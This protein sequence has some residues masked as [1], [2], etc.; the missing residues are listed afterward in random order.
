MGVPVKFSSK[1]DKRVLSELR[2][3]SK[4]S[5]RNISGVLTEAVSEYLERV[6]VR[7]A[8]KEAAS[9]VIDENAELL[10]RLAK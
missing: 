1:I 3:Y 6:R 8:F 7:P 4:Q 2:E 10:R 5:G 9:A